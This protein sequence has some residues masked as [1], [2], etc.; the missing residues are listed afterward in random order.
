MRYYGAS[1]VHDDEPVAVDASKDS[2]AR[3]L[4]LPLTVVIALL[5]GFWSSRRTIILL[6][7]LTG[8]AVL[9]FAISGASL[10]NNRTLLSVLLVI[11]WP[12]SVPWWRWCPRTAPRSR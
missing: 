9:V 5:D 6:S 12:A 10:V 1:I 8:V 7:A 4:G 2:F 3:L 11:R